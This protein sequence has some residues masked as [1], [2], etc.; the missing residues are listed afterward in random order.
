M[1]P[2]SDKNGNQIRLIGEAEYWISGDYNQLFRG[3]EN[4]LMN[5]IIYSFPNTEI[6]IT[7]E[8][9]K[10]YMHIQF[11]NHCYLLT[12]HQLLS[13]F[14]DEYRLEE[15]YAIYPEG[16]GQGLTIVKEILK[17]HSGEIEAKSLSNSIL[18]NIT[19]PIN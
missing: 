14:I 13:L 1:Q 16:T 18:F 2:W 3:F 6:R 5:A 7:I 11:F 19:L 4:L 12:T 15:A 17:E 10:E 8:Q 9:Q